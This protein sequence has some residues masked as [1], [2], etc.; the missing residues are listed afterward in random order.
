MPR[1]PDPSPAGVAPPDS[2]A[3]SVVELAWALLDAYTRMKAA[4]DRLTAA[5][6]QSTPRLGVLREVAVHGPS[7]VAQIARQR[8]VARQGIQRLADELVDAGLARFTPNP[9]HQ[10][11]PLLAL[12]RA[13]RDVTR[14][15]LARQ[16]AVARAIAPHLEPTSVRQ[17]ADVLRAF[18][19][20]VSSVD[21][22]GGMRG[23]RRRPAPRLT[24]R[25]VR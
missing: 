21:L 25:V 17:A 8:G 6:G 20:L 15:L 14:R 10:R 2:A 22:P 18:G 23:A 11:S 7:T 9:A 1:E 16:D 3:A 19:E 5:E 12:T 24:G 13:G 4:S